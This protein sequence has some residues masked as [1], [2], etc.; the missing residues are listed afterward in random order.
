ML[1]RAYRLSDKLGIVLLKSLVA[2]T[3]ATLAGLLLVRQAVVALLLLIARP[4]IALLSLVL[5]LFTRGGTAV[6]RAGVGAAQGEMAR[7]AA[8]RELDKS[9]IEDPLRRQNRLLSGFAVVTLLALVGVVLWATNPARQQ[10]LLPVAP[11][12]LPAALAAANTPQPVAGNSN[13]I[14]PLPT[15]I[16]TATALPDALQARGTIAYAGRANGQTDIYALPI[17]ARTPVRLTDDPA[18]DRDP[19]W[20]PDGRRLAFASNRGNNWDLYI[21]DYAADTLTRMTFGQ[22]FEANP[23]W[24]PD[25]QWLVYENYVGNNL[26]IWYVKVDGSVVPATLPGM[27]SAPDFSPAWSPDGREIAFV[28]W[29]DG[30]QDIYLLDLN[31]STLINLTN[32]PLRNEDYPAWSPDGRALAFSAL[33]EGIEKVFVQPIDQPTAQVIAGGRA[34]AWSPD[35]SSISYVTDSLASG[36][37]QLIAAPYTDAGV[38]TSIVSVPFGAYGTA[39]TG[40][41]LPQAVINA[42][43]QRLPTEALFIEQ[44]A[45]LTSDPAYRLRALPGVDAPFASLSERVDDSFNALRETTVQTVGWDFLGTLQDAFWDLNRLPEPGEPRRNWLMTGRAFG[46]NRNTIVGF[47]A[48]VEIVREDVGVETYWRVYVR[49]ADEAQ[50]GQLGEPLRQMPWDFLAR[51]QRDVQA[52]DE[53]G[54]LRSAMPAG[55]YI[56]FTQL[57]LDYGWLRIPAGGEWRANINAVN[58]WLF[59]KPEGR[60]WYSA[61]RELYSDGALINFAPT[62][63]PTAAGLTDATLTALPPSPPAPLPQGEGSSALTPT[64]LPNGEGLPE[65]SDNT[66]TSRAPTPFATA[67]ISLPS[68]DVPDV[69]VIPTAGN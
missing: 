19:A 68:T 18:E 16:P 63:A 56:D 43:I 20:S 25:G 51:D 34:P 14:N 50:V 5:G 36:S 60:D 59:Y 27:S 35:G 1:L 9:I 44:E 10:Q 67:P 32:T 55:Y 48:P 52:Y 65:E 13:P 8:R 42:G 61:M 53:G 11:A 57:A 40:T 47:P 24:S 62:A 46:F 38:I 3:D 15:P 21:Q 2:L 31:T 58:Y 7:R 29:R 22:A 23:A 30:N 45:P 64:P 69:P 33:D 39:W 6:A 4:I 54:R 26:D 41:P 28:S 12:G 37:A 49:V 17:G 66:P